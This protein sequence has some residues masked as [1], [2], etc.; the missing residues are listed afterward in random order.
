MWIARMSRD[1]SRGR[2]VKA[3]GGDRMSTK[4]LRGARIYRFG[5]FELHI[6]SGFC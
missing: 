2:G 4:T 1:D 5:E 3:S 6:R